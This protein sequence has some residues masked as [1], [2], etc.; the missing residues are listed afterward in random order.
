VRNTQAISV[1]IPVE[2]AEKLS[3]MQDE[4]K[5]NYSSIVTEALNQYILKEEIAD[6]R[7]SMSASAMKAGIFTEE[8]VI[9]VVHEVRKSVKKLKNHR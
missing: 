1:T 3:K 9:K 2:L 4:R 5:K 7:K 8:D 6:I